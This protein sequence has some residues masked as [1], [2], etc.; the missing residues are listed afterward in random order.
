MSENYLARRIFPAP[1]VA[2]RMEHIG[3]L[4][5]IAAPLQTRSVVDGPQA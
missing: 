5:A 4:N 2:P 1:F 3:L